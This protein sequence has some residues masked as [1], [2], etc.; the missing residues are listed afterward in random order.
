[1]KKFYLYSIYA[2]II[3]L[4]ASGCS[5]EKRLARLLEKHP[6]DPVIE[7]LP[8]EVRDSTIYDTIP[9][10]IVIDSFPFPVEIAAIIPD[11][12]ISKRTTHAMAT[13]S[14]KD[15]NLILE[16]IQDEINIETTIPISTPDTII[17]RPQPIVVEVPVKPKIFPFIVS[18]AIIEF[19][20]LIIL[21]F[22]LIKLKK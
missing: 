19:L 1:M 22:L 15:G 8:G 3:L 21:F 7:Y 13:A 20:L 14:I 5:V 18:A 10:E 9:G 6:Q 11:T 16:L 12:S 2:I 4:I 17:I